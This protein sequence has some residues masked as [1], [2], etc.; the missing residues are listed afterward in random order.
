LIELLACQ[1]VALGAKRSIKFTLIELLVVIA[2]IGI[3]ASMLLPALSKAR[4]TARK[5]ACMNNLKQVGLG[6]LSYAGDFNEMLPMTVGEWPDAA[7]SNGRGCWCWRARDYYGVKS[8]YAC[9]VL[10]CPGVSYTKDQIERWPIGTYSMVNYAATNGTSEGPTD[11]RYG[12]NYPYGA[13]WGR[14]GNIYG[15]ALYAVPPPLQAFINPSASYLLYEQFSHEVFKG[16]AGSSWSEFNDAFGVLGPLGKWHGQVGYKNGAFADGHVENNRTT[17]T[18]GSLNI[19][20]GHV[21]ARGKM[22]SITG[23]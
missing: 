17:E 2:I 10:R 21:A 16:M 15:G 8:N 18:Y 4:D 5:A 19:W 6:V 20:S 1:G 23:K 13:D 11:L 12:K 7:G 14:L 3:L 9:D 22:F